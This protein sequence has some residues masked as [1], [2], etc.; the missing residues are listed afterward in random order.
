MKNRA[1]KFSRLIILTAFFVAIMSG[2]CKKNSETDKGVLIPEKNFISILN[3]VY[4][5][6][7]LLSVPEIRD[8]FASRDSVTNY[9]EIIEKHG[10]TKAAMDNTVRYYILNTPK[11]LI[12]LYDQVIVQLSEM[13][14]RL[15]DEPEVVPPPAPNPY[16]I[17]TSYS[18]PD[19]EL[20]EKP[21]FE[22]VMIPPGYYNLTFTV[23]VYPD[24]KSVNPCFT[25][26]IYNADSTKSQTAEYLPEIKFH[27]NGFPYSYTVSGKI[28]KNDSLV[29]RAVLYDFE[30]KP[31]IRDQHAKIENI[32]FSCS[33]EEL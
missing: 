25:A 1:E 30:S 11:K 32:S 28:E 29:F 27:K 26:L 12:K 17:T 15:R 19:Q 22:I 6:D 10:Y 18:L 31:D 21:G 24:D 4:L 13:E 16:N 5:A 14:S 20:P 33:P 23:T 7:G 2:A 3:D 8:R 9:I